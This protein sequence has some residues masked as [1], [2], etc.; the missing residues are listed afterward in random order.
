MSFAEFERVEKVEKFTVF[1][2][3][4]VEVISHYLF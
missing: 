1:I 3:K 2:K 4:C